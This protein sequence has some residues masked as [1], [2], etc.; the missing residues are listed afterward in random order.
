MVLKPIRHVVR[1]KRCEKVRNNDRKR[2]WKPLRT[3]N[4]LETNLWNCSRQNYYQSRTLLNSNKERDMNAVT[5]TCRGRQS[6]TNVSWQ[7]EEKLSDDFLQYRAE[8]FKKLSEL[9]IMLVAHL[10]QIRT[11]RYRIEQ[12][13]PNLRWILSATY[14]AGW[15]HE[16]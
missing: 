13:F 16:G 6:I 2:E 12:S 14:L 4:K 15:K 7:G 3:E 10:G 8:L 1:Q 9:E 11:A 5:E